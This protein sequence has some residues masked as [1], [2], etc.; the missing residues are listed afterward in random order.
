MADKKAEK[1]LA[2][3][4][5]SLEAGDFYSALQMYRTVAIRRFDAG[6]I[7][8]FRSLIVSGARALASHGKPSEAADLGDLLIK[9]LEAKK[10][11][12]EMNDVTSIADISA[13][14]AEGGG[15]ITESNRSSSARS[16]TASEIKAHAIR[17]S[18]LQCAIRWAKSSPKTGSLSSSSSSA[19]AAGSGSG[20]SSA[21]MQFDA[22]DGDDDMI[23]T[24]SD[25]P[26]GSRQALLSKLELLAAR[27]CVAAGDE[28]YA[29]AQK[30]FVS[31]IGSGAECGQFLFVWCST[32]YSSEKELFLTRCVLYYLR[33]GNLRDA[34]A[35]RE[36]FIHLGGEIDTPLARFVKFLLLTAERDAQPLFLTLVDKYRPALLQRDAELMDLVTE[37]GQRF[38]HIQPTQN[39]MQE[40]MKNM[41]GLGNGKTP[42]NMPMMR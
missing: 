32:G 35:M 4:K 9:T 11:P 16:N 14:L 26:V 37:V 27:A 40:M 39:P 5:V 24:D 6:A 12:I 28:Y 2:Q 36:T 38:F 23:E 18:F 10:V 30:H 25:P 7:D 29:D 33:V 20:S 19:G 3:L 21:A 34:N 8:E 1:V 22:D 13:C 17:V 42:F 15:A 31:S 41:M